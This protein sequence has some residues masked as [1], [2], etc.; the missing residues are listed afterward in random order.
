MSRKTAEPAAEPAVEPT[1]TLVPAMKPS[2]GRIVHYRIGGTPE[3]PELRPAM[4]V[5][6][7]AGADSVQLQVFIDGVNDRHFTDGMRF[8]REELERGI[9]WRTS[10]VEGGAIGQWRWPARA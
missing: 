9:A 4:V 1:P 6:V 8:T 7:W 5:R 2:I 10:V 3:E